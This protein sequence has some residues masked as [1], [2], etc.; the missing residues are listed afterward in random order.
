MPSHI[1]IV[2]GAGYIGS[3][4][5]AR[6][7][8]TPY[9]VVIL[10]NLS[11]GHTESVL[12]GTF[13]QGDMSDTALLDRIFTEHPVTAVFHFAAFA[14]VG[15]SVSQ[16]MLYYQN[17]V[18]NTINLLNAMVRHKVP[19]FIF[20]S[21]C[22]IFGVPAQIPITEDLPYAPISPYGQTK[23]VV[24]NLLPEYSQAYGLKYSCLRYFNAAGADPQGRIGENHDPETHLIPLALGTL[25]GRFK[26][27]TIFGEDYPTPD[28]T[29]VRDYIHINDL[30]EAH[31]LALRRL[32]G[33]A[34]SRNY[35]LG[36]GKGFSVRQIIQAIETVTG[37]KVP[38][39]AGPR[40]PGDPPQLVGSSARAREELGWKPAFDLNAII[41]TAWNWH[42]KTDNEGNVISVTHSPAL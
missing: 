15:E 21:T 11:R 8:G 10:D 3:H 31:L 41:R 30:A 17:N 29:C 14:A 34:P 24:E 27:I 26:N 22:A 7:A 4:M 28:G 42:R 1:L 37:K 20:S 16:P 39:A 18:V 19:Y 23:L 38:V 9:P 25:T 5:V 40:R 32:E 35:N 2:G 12:N 33:G 6:L 36:N 13:I